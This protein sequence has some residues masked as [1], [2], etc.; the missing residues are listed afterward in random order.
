M[1]KIDAVLP[2]KLSDIKRFR[3]L[4]KSLKKYL[5]GLNRCWVIH[6]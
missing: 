1:R 6:S 4:E 2:L 5:K 3:I